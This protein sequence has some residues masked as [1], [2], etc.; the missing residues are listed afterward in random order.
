M[1]KG[2]VARA[3]AGDIDVLEAAMRGNQLRNRI[4]L[5]I[6][7]TSPARTFGMSFDS[8]ANEQQKK[9]VR[10]VVSMF[11]IEDADDLWSVLSKDSRSFSADQSKNQ[12]IGS[13]DCAWQ[14]RRLGCEYSIQL[15]PYPPRYSR[16]IRHTALAE[17]GLAAT[18]A[19]I[20]G[21]LAHLAGLEWRS[22]PTYLIIL[23]SVA[24]IAFELGVGWFVPQMPP[25]V[26]ESGRI[27]AKMFGR[28]RWLLVAASAKIVLNRLFQ[29][30]PVGTL[31]RLISEGC[32][33]DG[34]RL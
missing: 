5:A 1:S 6:S 4:I 20:G 19:Y 3:E 17:V 18:G 22:R 29:M 2:F 27:V 14:K 13:C 24:Q 25:R 7:T 9:K 16:R 33:W 11:C 8:L 21:Y 31:L 30:S 34:G 23:Q 32:G 26:M 28:G 15:L 10:A 12:F